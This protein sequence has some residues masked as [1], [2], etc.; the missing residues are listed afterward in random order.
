LEYALKTKERYKKMYYE[1]KP[2]NESNSENSSNV[3]YSKI[4]KEHEEKNYQEYL[5]R[6]QQKQ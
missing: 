4:S 5:K 6:Q 3:L 1:L 2:S